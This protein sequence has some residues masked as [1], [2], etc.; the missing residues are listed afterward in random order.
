[1]SKELLDR[2]TEA[3]SKFIDPIDQ[4]IIGKWEVEAKRAFMV[5][6]LKDHQGI[7]IILANFE[8][9]IVEIEDLLK[10]ARSKDLSDGDRDKL[11]DR[12]E[13]YSQFIKFFYEAEKSIETL[14]K[15][16]EEAV[17]SEN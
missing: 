1:M 12:K 6:S 7:K 2:I 16:V 15:Q 10:T 14:E 8:K 4:G 11:I 5:S 9:D 3:K 17:P 13:L